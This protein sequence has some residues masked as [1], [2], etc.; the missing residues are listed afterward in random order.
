MCFLVSSASVIFFQASPG[1]TAPDAPCTAV[2]TRSLPRFKHFEARVLLLTLYRFGA[3][4]SLTGSG[5]PP[6]SLTQNS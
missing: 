4:V 3:P 2:A 6:P 1:R 5:C